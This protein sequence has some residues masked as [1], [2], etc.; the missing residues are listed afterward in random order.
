M[1]WARAMHKQP[2]MKRIQVTI[3]AASLYA[4]PGCIVDATA[5]PSAASSSAHEQLLSDGES[6]PSW[7]ASVLR[8]R[9]ADLQIDLED[10][11]TV[12]VGS[13]FRLRLFDDV[14]VVVEM[15]ELHRGSSGLVWSGRVV[16]DPDGDVMLATTESDRVVGIVH[17]DGRRFELVPRDGKQMLIERD[18]EAMFD[19]KPGSF[20][21]VTAAIRRVFLELPV[22]PENAVAEMAYPAN[23]AM[24]PGSEVKFTWEDVDAVQHQLWLGASPGDAGYFNGNTVVNELTVVNLPTDGTQVYA[25]LFTLGIDGKWRSNDYSY[26]S[27]HE[28]VAEIA[29]PANGAMLPGSEVSFTWGDA[30][31]T[32]YEL[33]IGAFPGDSSFF[34]GFTVVNSLTVTDLPTGGDPIHARLWSFGMDGTWRHTDY[35]YTSHVD[36]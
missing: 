1:A 24:F 2:S 17:S 35:A 16:G 19:V 5:D 29:S 34:N 10:R 21:D 14:D 15:T 9:A 3:L 30:D 8:A 31:A 20:F 22:N 26:L 6:V 27:Y 28:G 23:G 18:A 12:S 25:R 33:W 32:Q 36:Q 13:S 7:H 11:N 4:L